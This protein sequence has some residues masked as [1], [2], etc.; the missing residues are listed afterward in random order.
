MDFAFGNDFKVCIAT[1]CYAG[2]VTVA[3]TSA[4]V[5]TVDVLR[6]VG[7][8]CRLLFNPADSLVTRARDYL[9]AQFLHDPDATHLM[10]IDADIGWEPAAVA[11]LLSRGRDIVGG[12]YPIKAVNWDDIDAA[13][14]AGRVDSRRH[15]TRFVFD[16][17]GDRLAFE[18]DLA[19]VK[20]LG[21]GFMMISRPALG[22]VIAETDPPWYRNPFTAVNEHPAPA[23]IPHL[24]RSEVADDEG[25]LLSEDYLFCREA[26]RA[27]LTIHLDRSVRLTHSGFHTFTGD[28]DHALGRLSG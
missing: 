2:Q 12:A 17:V 15:A 3:Y 13:A 21:T 10:F 26:R 27:G 11:R 5:A 14:R 28:L 9:A 23:E 7:V 24:F 1:P 18:G 16:P 25:I 4:L 6:Q 19:P 20:W 22:R 8:S